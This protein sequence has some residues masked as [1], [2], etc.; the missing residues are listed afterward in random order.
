M[1]VLNGLFNIREFLVTTAPVEVGVCIVWFGLDNDGE[2]IDGLLVL[3]GPFV[4]NASIVQTVN[5]VRLYRK[6]PSVVLNRLI[7]YANLPVTVP[8]LKIQYARLFSDLTLGA[9]NS[10]S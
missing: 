2:V 9:D 3:M 7:V 5:V 10:I 1:V 8:K 6:S 4:A